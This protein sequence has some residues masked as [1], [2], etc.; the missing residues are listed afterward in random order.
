MKRNILFI[1]ALLLSLGVSAQ[2]QIENS[3]F[4]LWENVSGGEEPNDWNGF[5][6]AS[7]GW[8]WAAA[9]QLEPSSDV[10]ASSSGV[11]S[12][13]IWTRDTG[14][15]LAQ[16]NLTIGRINM[17]SAT[18]DSPNDNYNYS[19]TTDTDFSQALSESPDSIVFWVK[20]TP[21][22][23]SSNARMKATLHD[24]YD[25]HDPEGTGGSADHVVAVAELNYAETSGWERKAIAFNYSGPASNHTNIL[26]TFATNNVPGGGDANDEV[27]VDDLELI[28][29]VDNVTE[30]NPFN[31]SVAFDLE[32]NNMI[33]SS[34][35]MDGDYAVFN[36]S[37]QRLMTGEISNEVLF[38]EPAGFYVV[39]LTIEGRLYSFN[40]V[41]Q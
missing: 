17:G 4:E 14:F 30:I 26:V 20:Y 36:S 24:D 41:K 1:G 7:G 29:N 11:Q 5:L 15:G 3:D 18:A 25:Y 38:T 31:A 39:V 13:R 23:S 12:A 33:I 9:D 40:V 22:N 16:G 27:L 35:V 8:N 6:T 32:N 2:S 10:P 21:G 34:D 37:G 19:V 28:Y